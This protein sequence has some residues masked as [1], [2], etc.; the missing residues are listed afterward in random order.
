MPNVKELINLVGQTISERKNGG[1]I[2]FYDGSHIRK[3]TV[4]LSPKTSAQCNF[5]WM[6]GKSTG[7]YRFK[8]A[9]HGLTAIPAVF[10]RVIDAILSEIPQAHAFIDDLLVVN[11]GTEIEHISAF[12][13]ILRE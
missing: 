6:R 11:K 2:F 9:L 7:V 8:T 12:E 4:S 1:S 3:R 13:K 5:P 10:Q